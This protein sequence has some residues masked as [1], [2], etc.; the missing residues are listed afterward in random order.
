[1][2]PSSALPKPDP[3]SPASLYNRTSFQFEHDSH[4]LEIF[5]LPR[6]VEMSSRLPEAYYSTADCGIADGW[7]RLGTRRS[8]RET[9]ETIAE[10]NSLVL[11]KHCER[12][13]EFGDRYRAIIEETVE[14]CGPQLRG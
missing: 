8:L 14:R 12:D 9:L 4:A 10:S 5:E 2:L 7:K 11:L 1:M 3:Q 13:P 6:I